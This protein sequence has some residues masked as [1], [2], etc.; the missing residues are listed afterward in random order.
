MPSGARSEGRPSF[1]DVNCTIGRMAAPPRHG[2]RTAE[3]LLEALDHAG[4]ERALVCH[5]LSLEAH[6]VVGNAQ[7]VRET[8]AL[9]RL[10]PC[11]TVLPPTTGEM[12]PPESLPA[13]MREAG[14]RAVRLCP[15]AGRHQFPLTSPDAARLLGV[16]AERRVPTLIDSAEV[17][18]GA[19]EAVAKAHPRLPLILLSV[20]YRAA[21]T[22]YPVLDAT[23]NVLIEINLYQGCGLLREGVERFGARRFLFGTGLPRFEPGCAV[24]SVLYA[25]VSAQDRRQVAGANLERLLREADL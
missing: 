11:W 15:S 20:G 7:A 13:A 10:W 18:W 4:V 8:A 21:R 22:A 25:A 2:P 14:V 19:V 24:A 16:L 9:P 23:E 6:P 17:S 3:A 12:A 1:F 5:S